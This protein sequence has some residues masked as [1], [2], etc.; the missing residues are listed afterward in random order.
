MHMVSRDV[1]N[2]VASITGVKSQEKYKKYQLKH[3]ML[4]IKKNTIYPILKT[5]KTIYPK[6]LADPKINKLNVHGMCWSNSGP[7]SFPGH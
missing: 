2:S 7:T 6:N 1:I 3:W 5:A 4:N